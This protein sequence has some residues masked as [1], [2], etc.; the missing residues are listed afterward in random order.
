MNTCVVLSIP[1]QLSRTKLLI[2]LVWSTTWKYGEAGHA[3]C[4]ASK[5]A[6]PRGLALVL[7]SGIMKIAPKARMSCVALGC[8]HSNGGSGLATNPEAIYR[9]LAT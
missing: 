9:S 8:Q 2:V 1:K 6:T 5:S 7:K 3:D 4:A